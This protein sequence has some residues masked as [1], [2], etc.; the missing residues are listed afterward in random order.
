M[1][2]R[3]SLTEKMIDMMNKKQARMYHL[4]SSTQMDGLYWVLPSLLVLA[5]L[6]IG[7]CGGCRSDNPPSKT[8]KEEVEKEKEEGKKEKFETSPLRVLPSSSFFNQDSLD[9]VLPMSLCVKPGHWV[10]SSQEITANHFD[11]TG[12]VALHITDQ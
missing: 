12:R 11:F 5:M 3:E 1:S 2:W 8:E 10:A 9:D 4:P 7:G 6:T